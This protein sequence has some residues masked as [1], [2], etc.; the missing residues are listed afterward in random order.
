[1]S[2]KVWRHIQAVEA[3]CDKLE[4]RVEFTGCCTCIYDALTTC[5]FI[6]R[7][8]LHTIDSSTKKQDFIM[9]TLGERYAKTRQRYYWV[10]RHVK[11]NA[12]PNQLRIPKSVDQS[13][14]RSDYANMHKKG[15]NTLELLR[16]TYLRVMKFFEKPS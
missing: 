6:N 15:L 13:Y 11:P 14:G 8:T 7:H 5:Y 12:F 3:A 1:M 10:A 4:A 9:S 16:D 2:N